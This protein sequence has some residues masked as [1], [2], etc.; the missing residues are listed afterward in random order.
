M[1]TLE[2]TLDIRFDIVIF[3]DNEAWIVEAVSGDDS[4]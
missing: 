1:K 4:E 3:A 2:S